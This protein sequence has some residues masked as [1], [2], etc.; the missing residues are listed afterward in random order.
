MSE[1]V[2]LLRAAAALIGGATEVRN[3]LRELRNDIAWYAHVGDEM[4]LSA[5]NEE[6]DYRNYNALRDALRERGVTTV[7]PGKRRQRHSPRPKVHNLVNELLA[8]IDKGELPVGTELPSAKTLAEQHGVR[9]IVTVHAALRA[10]ASEKRITDPAAGTPT[11]LPLAEE[12]PPTLDLTARLTEIS[13]QL[14]KLAAQLDALPATVGPASG[15]T[16]Q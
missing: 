5:V 14:K 4:L 10:L 1:T 2:A 16:E 12:T 6:G 7:V 11:V 15:T 13:Q 9:S 8:R 3:N